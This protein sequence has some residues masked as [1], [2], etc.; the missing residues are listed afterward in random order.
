MFLARPARRLLS[1]IFWFPLLFSFVL[2]LAPSLSPAQSTD[3]FAALKHQ[4]VELYKEGKF[5]DALPI[6]QKL[7]ADK[8]DDLVVL[9]GLAFCTLTHAQTLTDHDARKAERVKARQFVSQAQAAG[10]TSNLI[11]ILADIPADG[12]ESPLSSRADVDAL[13]Q[14][15]ETIFVKG[16]LDGAIASYQKALALDPKLY[17]AALFIGDCYFKKHDHEQAGRWFLRA[18]QIDPNQETAYRYWGDD[19]MAQDRPSD[20]KV[21]FVQ[22]IV[23]SPYDKR[24]WIGLI[25]WAKKADVTLAHPAINPPG[26]VTDKGKNDKGQA[27]INI[28]IDPGT[29]GDEADA[30]GTSAWFIYSLS[31]ANWHGDRFKKEFPNEKEYRHTL[32]EEVGSYQLVVDQVRDKLKSKKVQKLDPALASLV[33]LSDEGLLEPFVLISKADAGIAL[34]YPAY[35]DASREKITQYINEWIIHPVPGL[36]SSP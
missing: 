36:S 34:D 27:Q 19:L 11:K 25:Q 17:S 7:H 5:E 32:A 2:G 30:D 13:M 26:S 22:A 21:Q 4:A 18:I 16:D 33:K 31:K 24:S 9:E 12:S 3:D 14:E 1:A 28:T 6:F 15:G 29:M 20:A 23:A 10:D 8:P 35:R